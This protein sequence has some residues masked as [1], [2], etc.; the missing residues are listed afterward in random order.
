MKYL[1]LL[2]IFILAF[3]CSNAELIDN[4]KNPD[5]DVYSANKVL[6]VGMTSNSTA[7]RKFEKQ[8]QS[9]IRSR[10]IEA[11]T[12]MD[13]FEPSF[14]LEK[15]T[16]EELNQLESRLI[17][18]GFDTV[19]FTK[20]MGVEDRIVYKEN[21][22]RYDNTHKRFREDYLRYQDAFY[23]PDYYHEYSV[24]HSEISMYCICPTK[25]RELIWKGYIDITDP[26]SIGDTVNDYVNLVMVILEEQQLINPWLLNET[27]KVDAI[28]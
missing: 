28:K 24:Y 21:Y 12:S 9:E 1:Q 18:D 23:N 10:G 5:I 27:P 3:S 4:W 15:K 7:R 8:F 11:V 2:L 25:D 20:V 17:A 26:Q 22:R 16:E 13:Y 19:F 6:V 14:T